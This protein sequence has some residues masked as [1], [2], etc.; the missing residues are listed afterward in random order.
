MSDT[1]PSIAQLKQMLTAPGQP[2]EVEEISLDGNTIKTWK[3]APDTLA[4][5]VE[6][7]KAFGDNEY[8]VFEDERL[9]YAEHYQQVAR[10]ANHLVDQ[11]GLQQGDQVALAMRNYPEWSVAFWAAAA[12]GAIVV[13]MNAWWTSNE[14]EYGLRDSGAVLAIVDEERLQRIQAITTELPLANTLV[15]RCEKLPDGVDDLT[16]LLAQGNGEHLPEVDLG[17]EDDATLFYTSGTTGFP[18]GTLGSHRNFC[19]APMSG[20]YLG[21]LGMLRNGAGPEELAAMANFKPVALLPVPLFHVTG[22]QGVMAGMFSAGGKIVMMYKWNAELAADLIT[23]EN[24]TAFAGVPTMTRQLVDLPDIAQRDFSSMRNIGS[25]GAPV[26]PE[27]SRRL[28]QAFANAGISN[29]Y[30]ITETSSIITSIGGLDYELK[31][32]SAGPAAAVFDLK[33]V[34][35][36]GAEVATGELGEFWVRGPS[37]VKGY[38][39]RPEATAEAFVDGWYRTGDIGRVDEEGFL[40]IVDRLKDMIIRGG[41]NIYCAEVEAALSEHPEV[42][43]ACVF[44]I[45]DDI[46]GEQ[47]A[48]VVEI[49][50]Q[51]ALTE[52]E[53]RAFA[54]ETLATFKIPT[55]LWLR[56]DALPLGA[57]GKVQKKELRAYY[58]E[59]MDAVRES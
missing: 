46:L 22:C 50:P 30:G 49:A 53:L 23:A 25:G 57:T 10:L 54:G 20:Q 19:S 21:L 6:A 42:S 58:L 48:A 28:R 9:T 37:V 13:P 4:S 7:S 56:K 27:Q 59:Q 35:E 15:T 12:A 44:G 38:W 26:P 51:S 52:Q 43:V 11:Y 8:I 39:N 40:Y 17:P 3:H 41:E 5:I 18:K 45:P 29:G 2:F 55:K 31:P 24:I 14:M 16:S 34:A 47:V 36:N 33:V 1:R 32:A